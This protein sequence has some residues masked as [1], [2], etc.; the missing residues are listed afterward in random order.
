[1]MKRKLPLLAA[2]AVVA[3]ALAV[4]LPNAFGSVSTDQSDYAPGSVVTISGDNSNNAGYTSG[5]T[6]HVDVSGPNGYASSCDG[7]ADDS[8]AWSCQVTLNADDSAVG[9]YTYTA[10]GQSS[11]VSESGSFTD[12]PMGA[13]SLCANVSGHGSA[14]CGDISSAN[15]STF[16]SSPS[17]FAKSA[18]TSADYRIVAA[19]DAVDANGDNCLEVQIFWAQHG[20]SSLCATPSGNDLNFTFRAPSDGCNATVVSYES[21]NNV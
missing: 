4:F 12:A 5:E 16:A 11:G 8:G 19:T 1:M 17:C 7:V 18:C 15:V 3:A 14:V 20:T 9:S 21:R 13:G 10:T 6:V 2:L